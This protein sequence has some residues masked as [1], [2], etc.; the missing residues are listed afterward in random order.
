VS[1]AEAAHA[2]RVLSRMTPC[3][4][5]IAPER[6]ALEVAMRAL[7][8]V[9]ELRAVLRALEG[10]GALELDDRLRTLGAELR[11]TGRA[12]KPEGGDS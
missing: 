1:R 2:L 7:Q 6:V 4:A 11:G 3:F 12:T 10:D 9:E 8:T 5:P